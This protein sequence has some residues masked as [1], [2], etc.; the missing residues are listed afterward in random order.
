MDTIVTYTAVLDVREGTVF[1][2]VRSYISY[3]GNPG[4]LHDIQVETPGTHREGAL[5]NALEPFM[6]AQHPRRPPTPKSLQKS[7][8]HWPSREPTAAAP[9]PRRR[10]VDDPSQLTGHRR[11]HLPPDRTN[12]PLGV[13]FIVRMLDDLAGDVRV[14]VRQDEACWE[15]AINVAPLGSVGLDGSREGACA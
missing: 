6:P 14:E 4:L 12:R 11:L 10:A 5:F 13:H 3:T 8:T 2:R 7:H 1:F 9:R 15:S